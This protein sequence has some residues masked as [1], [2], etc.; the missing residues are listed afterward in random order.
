VGYFEVPL[1]EG[2]GVCSDDDCVCG[3]AAIVRGAGYLYV[4]QETVDF[5]SNATSVEE[6]RA[7]EERVRSQMGDMDEAAAVMHGRT[8]AVLICEHS[9][10][11]RGIDM[12]VAGADAGHWWETGQAPLRATPEAKPVEA[13]PAKDVTE[14]VVAEPAEE[15]LKPKAKKKAKPKA[16]TAETKAKKTTKTVKSKSEKKKEEGEGEA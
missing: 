1:P 5:R 7:K 14:Q 16:K 2:D 10:R 12:D 8:T 3:G 11:Q 9:A 6:A 15:K 4:D 13:E